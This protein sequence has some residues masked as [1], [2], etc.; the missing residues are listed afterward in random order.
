MVEP[1]Y[2][3]TTKKAKADATTE[4]GQKVAEREAGKAPPRK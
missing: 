1:K 4:L 2:V 3:D